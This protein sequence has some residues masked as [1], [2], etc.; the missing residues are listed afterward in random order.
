MSRVNELLV[1]IRQD[2]AIG[3]G[4]RL[5]QWLQVVPEAAAS[6]HEMG[7]ELRDKRDK[8]LHGSLEKWIEHMIPDEADHAKEG[9]ITA[10]GG[11]YAFIKEYLIYWRDADW[12]D[13]LR[14]HE[15]L[16]SVV[17]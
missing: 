2:I 1:T 9:Q 5:R 3:N 16:T 15:L 6:Y 17:K 11:L 10:W 13:L 4:E 8:P 12:S 14:T 7:Q